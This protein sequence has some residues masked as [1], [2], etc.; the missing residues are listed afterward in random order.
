MHWHYALLRPCSCRRKQ[1]IHT[2]RPAGGLTSIPPSPLFSQLTEI[3]RSVLR[4]S[5]RLTTA[6][7]GVISGRKKSRARSA[8]P[9]ADAG[10]GH[11]TASLASGS[12]IPAPSMRST[13]D[14][15]ERKAR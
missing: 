11:I 6:S 4:A 14:R 8:T 15:R 2:H 12:A 10:V 5:I 7:T 9:A 13:A 3:S 1:S